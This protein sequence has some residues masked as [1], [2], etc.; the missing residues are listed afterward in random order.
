[1]CI[2][3]REY[4]VETTNSLQHCRDVKT[5]VGYWRNPFRGGDDIPDETGQGNAVIAGGRVVCRGGWP[6]ISVVDPRAFLLISRNNN[7]AWCA[8]ELLRGAP[9]GAVEVWPIQHAPTPASDTTNKEVAFALSS[10]GGLPA[11]VK[12][13]EDFRK[14]LIGWKKRLS[15]TTRGPAGMSLHE[16]CK[17][18][19]ADSAGEAIE[20]GSPLAALRSQL[21]GV[22]FVLQAHTPSYADMLA[23]EVV[24][25]EE[26]LEAPLPR[27]K[28]TSEVSVGTNLLQG[29]RSLYSCVRADG[30][31]RQAAFGCLGFSLRQGSGTCEDG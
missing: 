15:D 1:M 6:G 14:R 20:Y 3:G 28:I 24:H 26:V 22:C 8:Y 18:A 29:S 5:G 9:S 7:A 23:L 10:L 13:G 4:L 16:R 27:K 19:V 31:D 12:F 17:V 25:A 2:N 11:P 21:F 30:K